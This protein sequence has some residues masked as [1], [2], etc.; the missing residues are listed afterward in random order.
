M[1]VSSF[2]LHQFRGVYLFIERANSSG[3]QS[4]DSFSSPPRSLLRFFPL[5][6]FFFFVC[7]LIFLPRY[8]HLPLSRGRPTTRQ[9]GKLL[10]YASFRSSFQ[11]VQSRGAGGEELLW[12]FHL[13][14]CQTAVQVCCGFVHSAYSWCCGI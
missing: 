9:Q 3:H 7:R 14:L 11:L 10:V 1:R 8:V 2:D 6:L 4:Y 5:F 13:P 12:I